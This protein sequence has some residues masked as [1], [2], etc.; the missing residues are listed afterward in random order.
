MHSLPVANSLHY[1]N[2]STSHRMR[3]SRSTQRPH[4]VGGCDVCRRVVAQLR[5]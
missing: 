2:K 4:L 3:S 1:L 5:T